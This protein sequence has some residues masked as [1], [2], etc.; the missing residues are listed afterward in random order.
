MNTQSVER[1]CRVETAACASDPNICLVSIASNTVGPVVPLFAFLY[2]VSNGVRSPALIPALIALTRACKLSSISQSTTG[3]KMSYHLHWKR[4]RCWSCGVGALRA[5]M[6]VGRCPQKT[7]IFPTEC[8][9]I[10]YSIGRKAESLV[11]D[12]DD[13]RH[14]TKGTVIYSLVRDFRLIKQPISTKRR[15]ERPHRLGGQHCR[16]YS[17]AVPLA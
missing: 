15:S 11:V 14:W 4:P 13:R 10:P 3:M 7:S 9:F 5:A 16:R 12:N 6:D 8:T 17:L 2:A 1:T